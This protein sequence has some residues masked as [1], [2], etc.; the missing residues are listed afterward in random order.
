MAFRKYH[1]E[2]PTKEAN[3][4]VCAALQDEWHVPRL[5]LTPSGSE[6]RLI[7]KKE[8]VLSR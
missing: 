5:K 1:E 2:P 3:K 4:K 8:K 7:G 6:K